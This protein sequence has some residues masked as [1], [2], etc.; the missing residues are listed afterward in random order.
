MGEAIIAASFERISQKV[1]RRP[2]IEILVEWQESGSSEKTDEMTSVLFE[3]AQEIQL[4]VGDRAAINF[5][6]PLQ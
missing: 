2:W 3:I 4:F 6:Y 5:D 1:N